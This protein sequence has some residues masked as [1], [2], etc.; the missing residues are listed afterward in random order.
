MTKHLFKFSNYPEG[1]VILYC[2]RKNKFAFLRFRLPV[3]CPCCGELLE[4]GRKAK[5]V[6]NYRMPL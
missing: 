4:L 5:I 6:L 3:K 2:P 1:E